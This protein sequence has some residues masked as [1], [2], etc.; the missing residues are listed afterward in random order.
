[1]Y[2]KD[3]KGKETMIPVAAPAFGRHEPRQRRPISQPPSMGKR[4]NST[5]HLDQYNLGV[6]YSESKLKIQLIKVFVE[7]LPRLI[8][9]R[10]S[11][12]L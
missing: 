8:Q 4:C 1:M 11:F 5:I 3:L 12:G 10:D 7:D 9:A 6:S 2:G